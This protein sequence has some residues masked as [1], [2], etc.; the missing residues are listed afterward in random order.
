MFTPHGWIRNGVVTVRDDG[1]ILDIRAEEQVDRLPG[2]EFYS[3]ALL[4]GLVNGHCHLELSHL[5]GAISPGCGF[6]GFA[7]GISAQRD[8]CSEAQQYETAVYQ[9]ARMWAEGTA[10]VGDIC[11]R[12]LTFPLK[13]TSP[14]RYHNF[15]ELFGL[16]TLSAARCETLRDE[17]QTA[18]LRATVTPHATYSLNRQAFAAAIGKMDNSPLS[19]HFMET[20]DEAELFHQRG[21][22]QQWY[23]SCGLTTDF[24]TTYASPAARIVAEIPGER[25]LLLIHN[26]CVTESDVDLLQDHFGDRLTWVLCPRSNHYIS[27]LRPPVELLRR[28]G[29]HIAIGTDSLASNESLSLLEELKLFPEIPLEELLTWATLHGAQALEMDNQ[30]GSLEP[31]KQPGVIL[32]TGMDWNRMTLTPAAT[33]RRLI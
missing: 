4:P 28:K 11:N 1:T 10:A 14:I 7:A 24:T 33:T 9:D 16:K 23:D 20:P 32:L 13:K 17:A 21:A 31:G 6:P 26:T 8:H 12:A 25:R 19:I 27:G 3:G 18:G 22:L 5:R 29:G 2:V 15:I 30:L